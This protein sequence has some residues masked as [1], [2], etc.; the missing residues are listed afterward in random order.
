MPPYIRFQ[1]AQHV[2]YLLSVLDCV[3]DTIRCLHQIVVQLNNLICL[4]HA[5][6]RISI[7]HLHIC[8]NMFFNHGKVD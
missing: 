2:E 6:T 5:T 4:L 7:V 8:P 1:V 3:T